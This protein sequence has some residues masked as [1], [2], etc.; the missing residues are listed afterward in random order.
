MGGGGTTAQVTPKPLVEYLCSE[1]SSEP[2]VQVRLQ[3][4]ATCVEANSKGNIT[5]LKVTANGQEELIECDTVLFAAG[6]WTGKLMNSSLPRGSSLGSSTFLRKARTI[7]GSR[8][9]SIVIRGTRPTTEHCLF[10]DMRY[11][12]EGNSA[13]APEVYARSDG[14][15]YICGGSD[16]V[17]LPATAD[18]VGFDSKQTKKLIEQAQVLSPMVLGKEATIEKEQACYLPGGSFNGPL[19]DGSAESGL[20]VAAGHTC[21]GITLS[22]GTGKVISELMLEGKAKSAD[23]GQLQA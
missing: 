9:H 6:P 13:G 21:W 8:A 10:T 15:V 2:D 17:A 18:E 16:S 3:T 4:S 5:G 19:I 12:P 14:T 1:A 23:I 11:G 22:L 20:W 7:D